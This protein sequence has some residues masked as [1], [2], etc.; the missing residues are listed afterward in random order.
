MGASRADEH[1]QRA[2]LGKLATKFERI[3][4]YSLRAY[5]TEDPIFEDRPEMRLITRTI[6]LNEVFSQVFT[7]RGHTRYFDDP[8][9]GDDEKKV[10]PDDIPHVGFGFGGDGE[11]DLVSI[12]RPERFYCPKPSGEPI[13]DHIDH[14]F[15]NSR[16]PELGTVSS[17][18][19]LSILVH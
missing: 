4:G 12:V 11:A 13:I 7:Q 8:H 9:K 14:V 19:R 2:Y 5:Y 10:S 1:S 3:V 15:R 18:I 6:E 17:K 16:G